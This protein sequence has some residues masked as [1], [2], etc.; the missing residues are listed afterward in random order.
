MSVFS[1]AL[2]SLARYCDGRVRT[3]HAK[4]DLHTNISH[5]NMHTVFGASSICLH[6]IVCAL[7][8]HSDGCDFRFAQESKFDLSLGKKWAAAVMENFQHSFTRVEVNSMCWM[9]ML[10][11]VTLQHSLLVRHTQIAIH[12][13]QWTLHDKLQ[14]FSTN[15]SFF[16]V[17]VDN[18]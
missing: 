17:R 12:N 6:K 4:L 3:F 15:I 18:C 10:I 14:Y 2:S 5:P 11:N 7:A 13:S 9:W 1:D 8:Q 16:G